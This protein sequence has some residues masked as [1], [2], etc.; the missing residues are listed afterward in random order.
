MD[1]VGA[2]IMHGNMIYWGIIGNICGVLLCI[3]LTNDWHKPDDPDDDDSPDGP[4]PTPNGD[5]IDRWLR[6]Q[7]KVK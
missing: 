6:E 1:L 5:A 7:Q 4:D 2:Y 3:I